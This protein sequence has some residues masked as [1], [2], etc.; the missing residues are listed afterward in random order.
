MVR[1]NYDDKNLKAQKYFETAITTVMN[2]DN[3]CDERV[4]G[5]TN[6]TVD[7]CLHSQSK[8]TDISARGR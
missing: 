2:Y 8:E 6:V 4:T 5:T 3:V 7:C 1:S